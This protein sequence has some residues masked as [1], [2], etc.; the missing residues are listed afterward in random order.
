[1]S[2]VV[3][4]PVTG[5]QLR[6]AQQTLE[7]VDPSGRLLGHFVPLTNPSSDLEPKISEEELSRRE[8]EGG[9]R[10]LSAILADLDKTA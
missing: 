6:Q 5:S 1:M 7:L 9:G 10:P 3:V 4:D 8:H 2:R